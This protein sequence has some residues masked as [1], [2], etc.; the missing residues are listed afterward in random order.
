MFLRGSC[1]GELESFEE[2]EPL[3][4][5]NSGSGSRLLFP[6]CLKAMHESCEVKV[7]QQDSQGREGG[8]RVATGEE[9]R[10]P[11]TREGVRR[12]WRA[13]VLETQPQQAKRKRIPNALGDG[14][15]RIWRRQQHPRKTRD[16]EKEEKQCAKCRAG[17][18]IVFTRRSDAHLGGTRAFSNKKCKGTKWGGKKAPG[19]ST[20]HN[21]GRP[22]LRLPDGTPEEAR[23]AL[24]NGTSMC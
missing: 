21:R 2:V 6:E 5:M 10:K 14:E 11:S 1:F 22:G 17:G 24:H 3:G 12:V 13:L 9:E 4:E 15:Q 19:K 23:P 18:W 16:I 20:E 8:Y 7:Q